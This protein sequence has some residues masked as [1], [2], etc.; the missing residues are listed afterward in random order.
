VVRGREPLCGSCFYRRSV[1]H[2]VEPESPRDELWR[3]VADQLNA[4]EALVREILADIREV[5]EQ[6]LEGKNRTPFR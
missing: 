5:R 2:P 3:R 4:V 1:H 6:T